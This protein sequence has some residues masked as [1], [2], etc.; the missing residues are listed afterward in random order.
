MIDPKDITKMVKHIVRRDAGKPDAVIMHPMREWV[1]GLGAIGC[2]LIA[3]VVLT[4]VLYR[5]YNDSLN[6]ELPVTPTIIPYKAVFVN[7]T[8]EYYEAER[9]RYESLLDKVSAVGGQSTTT[10]AVVMPTNRTN[11][12]AVMPDRPVAVPPAESA[13]TASGKPVVPTPAL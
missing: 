2:I 1:M 13:P 4:V 10:N 3:G 9:V 7:D 6:T 5:T 11:T 8:I 12:P